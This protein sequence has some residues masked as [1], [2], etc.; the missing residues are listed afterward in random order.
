MAQ[1]RRVELT[2]TPDVAFVRVCE[3]MAQVGK[4]ESTSEIS[5]SLV[6]KA[7][8]GLNP[9]RVRISVMGGTDPSSSVVEFSGKGQDVWG[10]A[11]RKVIDRI[12]DAL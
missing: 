3:V 8:Y 4:V 2:V 6:G 11:P 1:G 9:V 12:V 10:A 5:R 7:R